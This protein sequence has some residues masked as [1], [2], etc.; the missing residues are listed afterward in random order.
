MSDS[1][2][3]Q[4]QRRERTGE[5]DP[6]IVFVGN[7]DYKTTWQK[8]KDIFRRAG[9][10]RFA[11]LIADTDGRPKGSALVTFENE[12]GATAAIKMFH[13][14]ELD[15]RRI[16]VRRFESGRRPAFVRHHMQPRDKRRRDDPID[17]RDHGVDTR[18]IPSASQ[19]VPRPRSQQ[20][21]SDGKLFVSNL[22]FECTAQSLHDTFSQ[23]GRVVDASI[24]HSSNGRS[25]GMGLVEFA[26]RREAEIAI[27]EFDGIEMAGRPMQVRFERSAA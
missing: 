5:Y 8:L 19:E 27:Q 18:R 7:L 26:E 20:K 25:R 15:G 13:D 11:D 14:S 24:I 10:V 2:D 9:P 1:G 21:R 16:L 22:P 6:N 17:D 12:T 4:G 3:D 23:V